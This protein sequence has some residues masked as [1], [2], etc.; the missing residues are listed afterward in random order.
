MKL[1]AQGLGVLPELLG[2]MEGLSGRMLAEVTD[3]LG[4]LEE[5]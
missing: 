5:L 1:L 3:S 2:K 4:G